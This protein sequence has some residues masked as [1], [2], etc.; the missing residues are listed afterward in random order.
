MQSEKGR[1][2]PGAPSP[3]SRLFRFWS[4]PLRGER[5]AQVIL[6][7]AGIVVILLIVLV[8]LVAIPPEHP[9]DVTFA[10]APPD[11]KRIESIPLEPPDDRPLAAIVA[12]RM[13]VARE[14][15]LGLAELRIRELRDGMERRFEAAFL[16]GYLSFFRRKFAEIKAYNT[17]ALDW[18]HNQW[19]GEQ[20]DRSTPALI[21]SFE[22]LFIEQVVAPARS[23]ATLDEIGRAVA[24]VY[25]E[26]LATALETIRQ[27]HGVDPQAWRE[28]LNALPLIFFTGR[29]GRVLEIRIGDG[30]D[31]PQRFSVELG[32][33]LAHALHIRF[34]RTTEI[35]DAG[36]IRFAT[37]ESV[38]FIGQNVKFYYGSFV[39]Y[40]L[41]L[42]ILLRLD[43]VPINLFGAIIGLII[44]E[45]CAW[46]S[47]MIYEW[48]QYDS[49]RRAL[50]PA[51][52]SFAASYLDRVL[53]LA[54]DLPSGGSF[55][56][57]RQIEL[58]HPPP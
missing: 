16:P 51:I 28:Q 55:Q 19:T 45:V 42:L 48:W 17:F 10:P 6:G 4:A 47:W 13:A 44:W 29:D 18:A 5:L 35:L 8:F 7:G 53:D 23:R 43:L 14:Q 52:V 40:W 58:F 9:D 50:E 38:F 25:V 12:D 21:A 3:I 36:R 37:G 31:D 15:A 33:A 41:G 49:M 11:D 30:I 57:L 27:Q 34:E 56:S 1:A 22:D 32:T 39:V 20:R 54:I 26:T 46:G 2:S 24:S